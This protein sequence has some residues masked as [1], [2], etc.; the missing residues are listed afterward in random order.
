MTSAS[1][2]DKAS[3]PAADGALP[4]DLAALEGNWVSATAL[5][6]GVS[7]LR[8]RQENGSLL[9]EAS[10]HDEPRPG[11]WGEVTADGVFASSARSAVG[12]AFTVTFDSDQMS[13]QMQAYQGLGVL[14]GHAFHRF[15][16]GRRDYFTREFYVPDKNGTGGASHPVAG[17]FPAA[18][19]TGGNAPTELLGT[20]TCLASATTTRNVHAL[21]CT[22]AGDG[23]AVRAYGV[24]RDEPA[25]WGTADARL[26]AD[27]ARPDEPP[28]FL[29]TF[30][31]GYMCVHLQ[32]RI[33]RG[34]LVVCEFTKFTDGNG[35]SDY[36]IRECFRR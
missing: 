24:L 8:A 19:R 9:V 25:D 6:G 17:G 13:S 5:A 7:R 36:F 28:A 4:L 30:D 22:A 16:D 15:A 11:T 29:A 12:H 34:V 2:P 3:R 31:Q 23:L 1:Q 20:W 14:T 35:R 21:R 32:A 26:Y 10:G 18:L 33:N 27:A